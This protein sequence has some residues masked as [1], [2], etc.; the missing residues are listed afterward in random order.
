M[1]GIVYVCDVQGVTAEDGEDCIVTDC[2]VL[3]GDEQKY[4]MY[5]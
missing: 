5:L 2:S 1:S 4:I 3:T